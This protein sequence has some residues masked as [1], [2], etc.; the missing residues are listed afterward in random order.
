M[1]GSQKN[2]GGVKEGSLSK[3]STPQERSQLMKTQLNPPRL[4]GDINLMRTTL[5]PRAFSAKKK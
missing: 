2:T 4:N 1:S 3:I 5:Q